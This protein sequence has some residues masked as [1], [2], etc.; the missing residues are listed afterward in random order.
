MKAMKVVWPQP[1]MTE[2]QYSFIPLDGDKRHQN[3]Y[4]T[5]TRRQI[6]FAYSEKNIYKLCG[7]I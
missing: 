1:A 3:V 2:M 4:T 7:C 6:L 5:F